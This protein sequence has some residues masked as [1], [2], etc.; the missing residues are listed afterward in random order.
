[1]VNWWFGARS[2][3]LFL[4]PFMKEIAFFFRGTLIRIP[5]HQP[6]PPIYH[7]PLQV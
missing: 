7:Y 2:F 6:K 3:G 1:M 4:D 5:N